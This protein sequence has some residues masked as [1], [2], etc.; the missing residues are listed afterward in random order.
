LFAAA[1]KYEIILTELEKKPNSKDERIVKVFEI[2]DQILP[3]LGVYHEI[4]KMAR[5]QLFGIYMKT[6]ASVFK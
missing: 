1:T 2:F 5:Q 4:M 3:N 6:K